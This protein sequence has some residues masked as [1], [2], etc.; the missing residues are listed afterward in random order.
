MPTFTK[1]PLSSLKGC[2]FRLKN[3][4]IERSDRN[5]GLELRRKDVIIERF[6]KNILKSSFK[7]CPSA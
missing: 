3:E 5:Y 4:W 6:S 2:I 1:D 7:V